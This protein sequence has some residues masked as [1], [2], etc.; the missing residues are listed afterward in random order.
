[1]EDLLPDSDSSEQDFRTLFRLLPLACCVHDRQGQLL[2]ANQAFWRLLPPSVDLDG[3]VNLLSTELLNVQDRQQVARHW[4]LLAEGGRCFQ[5]VRLLT[6]DS[7]TQRVAELQTVDVEFQGGRQLL[8]TFS[9]ISRQK[10]VE[11][12]LEDQLSFLQ[13]FFDT[14][15]CPAF[16][17]NSQGTYL[18]CNVAFSQQIIGIAPEKLIGHSLFDLPDLIPPEMARIYYEHDNKLFKAGG[19]QVYETKVQ[20]A[21]GVQRDFLFSKSTFDNAAGEVAGLCGVMI[22]LTQKVD[23]EKRLRQA[24]VELQRLSHLDAMTGIGNR[25]YFDLNY[26]RYWQESIAAETP[27]SLIMVDIDFFKNYNDHY[28]HPAGDACIRRVAEALQGHVLRE[29][30]LVARY[31]GEEFAI[32]LP[33]TNLERASAIAER[34]RV[35]IESLEIG[36]QQS[37]VAEHVTISLGICSVVPCAKQTPQQLLKGADRALYLSKQQGRNRVVEAQ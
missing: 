15:P 14:I 12:L 3:A 6:A 30:D 13:G 19:Q 23:A 28:G 29:G 22:D 16:Y 7:D 27:L 2:D 35:A 10:Q 32:L 5:E 1:M 36:H 31:G 25:R 24:N 8:T 34:V 18:G 17:K 9:N 4:L 33:D 20:C 26:R 37:H 21:D 11:A